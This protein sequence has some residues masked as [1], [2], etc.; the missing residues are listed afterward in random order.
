VE[1]L[2]VIKKKKYGK[3]GLTYLRRIKWKK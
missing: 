2:E 1:G 3:T